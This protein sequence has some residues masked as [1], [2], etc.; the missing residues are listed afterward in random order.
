MEQIDGIEGSADVAAHAADGSYERIPT[1]SAVA[2]V[3]PWLLATS[4]DVGNTDFEAPIS[5]LVSAES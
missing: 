1:E 4:A 2:L 3:A 5:G